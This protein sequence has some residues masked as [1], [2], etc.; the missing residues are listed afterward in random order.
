MRSSK[1]I[2]LVYYLVYLIV[3]AGFLFHRSANPSIGPY[4]IEHTAF[5]AILALGFFVP[6]AIRLLSRKFGSKQTTL[7]LA[8]A[9]FAALI[10]YVLGG[11]FY[12]NTRS[13]P[14]DPYLQMPPPNINPAKFEKPDNT[15]RIITLGGSSTQNGGLA[16]EH[17]YT[18]VL[19]ELLRGKYPDKK[20][21]LFN[22]GMMWYTTK[23]SLINYTTSMR[24]WEP[25]M[26][27]IMHAINDLVRSCEDKN[28]TVGQ[29]NRQW[30]HFYGPSINGAKPITFEKWLLSP[31]T[32]IWFS[33][34]KSKEQD[35]PLEDFKSKDDF[36]RNLR[37]LIQY[38][39]A[40]GVVPI[41]MT[42]PYLYKDDMD[43]KDLSAIG[44][45]ST[46]CRDK[47][48]WIR[49]T[50]PS[51]ASLNRAMRAY[52]L[53]AVEVAQSEGVTVIDAEPALPKDLGYFRDDVH[54]TKD[55]ASLLAETVANK[56]AEEQIIKQISP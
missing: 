31:F 33:A 8:L 28:F 42:Q 26:A 2:E 48:D 19:L 40:D 3:F 44:F 20:I 52:N 32:N 46:Y 6:W 55:G 4:S 10:L 13:H 38:L 49:Y 22:A 23:H 18:T 1:I 45:G 15:I 51:A 41:V 34:L 21:E 14:F 53:S 9:G 36:K 29:Y 47:K 17:K 11:A 35:V 5:L 24:E 50:Y 7:A 27:I 37:T 12:Y 56:I 16:H 43:S 54:Y 30:S 39:K 25:D